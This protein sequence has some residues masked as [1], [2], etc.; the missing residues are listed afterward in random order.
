MNVSAPSPVT[1]VQYL[2]DP[3]G[4]RPYKCGYCK[5]PDTSITQGVW[6]YQMT[7]RDYQEL[8]D[9]GFQR[10]GKY[11]YRPFMQA[12]CCPQ[13]VI[14]TDS[15]TFRMTKL[16]R[17]AVR[18]TRRYLQLGRTTVLPTARG[19]EAEDDMQL[20]TSATDLQQTA[21][22]RADDDVAPPPEAMD[23]LTEK[24]TPP[25]KGE[26]AHGLETGAGATPPLPAHAT[27]CAGNPDPT[28]TEMAVVRGTKPKKTIKPGL[29]P[30]PTKPLCRKA[31]V[32]RREKKAQKL[33]ARRKRS[34]QEAM[35][36]SI[37]LEHNNRL[38]SGTETVEGGSSLPQQRS[39]HQRASSKE[40]DASGCSL[41]SS[42]DPVGHS[43]SE[44]KPTHPPPPTFAQ[45]LTE[46]LELS[47]LSGDDL[48]HRFTTR[49]VPC[50]RSSLLFQETFEESYAVFKKFQ[51][52]IHKEK[53]EDCLERQFKEFLVDT[54]LIPEQGESGMPCG[55]GSYHQHYLLD[56]QIFAVGVLDILPRGVLCEYL[57]YDPG[58]RFI[59]PGVLTALHEIALTQKFYLARPSMRFYYM[60]FYVQSCPKMNY[61]SR[62]RSSYLLCSET[63]AYVPIEQCVPKL[64][65]SPYA[66]LAG[67]ETPNVQE[68]VSEAT[69][70]RLVVCGPWGLLSYG[71]YRR[72]N[73]DRRRRLVEEYVAL[74]G[75][76]V[77]LRSQLSLPPE[78]TY[79]YK[80]V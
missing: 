15:T 17:A 65:A 43:G 44:A 41:S 31:K 24:P 23:V 30:D 19:A 80:S 25:G 50:S 63:H 38:Q 52:V 58:Y 72:K 9:R 64:K 47:E 1:I 5:S 70:D 22:T 48:H 67:A 7:C 2:Y 57:Y 76:N 33:A 12:T 66:R 69:I 32:I 56:G 26:R 75:A 49:L 54:P 3:S 21:V 18:K 10:S 51:T 79:L 4:P 27:P 28:A 34:E 42:V 68:D 36:R 11:V 37:H 14:R 71:D 16:Q 62:Y 77:A 39:D 29:G 74:V 35:E 8:V 6:A 46:V 73:G 45:D 59:A 78:F 60:G 61:K 55:Y 13:Y 53:E 40:D 20:S